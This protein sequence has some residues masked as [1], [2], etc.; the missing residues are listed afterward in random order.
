MASTQ[1][2]DLAVRLIERPNIA[3]VAT[4]LPDGGPHVAP[5]WIALLDGRVTFFTG[6]GTRKAR[7][8]AADPR[9]AISIVDIERWTEFTH[10]RGVIAEVVDGESGWALVDRIAQKYGSAPYPRDEERVAYLVEV[11]HALAHAF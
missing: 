1:L 7:N 10:L 6:P 8:L 9:V 5:T 3:H 2:P 4:V 11:Q